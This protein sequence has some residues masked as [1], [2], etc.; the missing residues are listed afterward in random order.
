MT[1]IDNLKVCAHCGSNPEIHQSS[2]YPY[3]RIACKKC[4]ITTKEYSW[5]SKIGCQEE[6]YASF[7]EAKKQAAE[8]WNRRHF[9]E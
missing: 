4:K 8:N 7:L 5:E 9:S 6:T 1:T 2:I 3:L